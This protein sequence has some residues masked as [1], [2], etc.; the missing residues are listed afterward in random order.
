MNWNWTDF[1]PEWTDPFQ[2]R[3]SFLEKDLDPIKIQEKWSEFRIWNCCVQIL[4]MYD[5]L[6]NWQHH[7]WVNF[8]CVLDTKQKQA[9][10]QQNQKGGRFWISQSDN[11]KK[12]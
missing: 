9:A 1:Y 8:S 3:S 4:T 7:L 5:I 12:S 2:I 11:S 10:S 6:K